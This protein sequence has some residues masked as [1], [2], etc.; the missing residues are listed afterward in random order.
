[1]E[2]RTEELSAKEALNR[3]C[4]VSER[5]HEGT[6]YTISDARP[7]AADYNGRH[8]FGKLVYGVMIYEWWIP[9]VVIY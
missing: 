5:H 4:Y 9:D 8:V 2:T 6:M 7:K 1:M 3:F